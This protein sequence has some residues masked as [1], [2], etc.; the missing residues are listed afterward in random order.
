CRVET[1]DG[2]HILADR[3]RVKQV[4]LNLLSNA[5]KYNREGGKVTVSWAGSPDGMLHIKVADTG[6]G[7]P[8]DQMERLFSEFDRLG[9]EQ[10]DVEGT[11]LG[12]CLSR[13]LVQAMGGTIRVESEVGTGS[14]FTVELPLAEPPIQRQA[15]ELEEHLSHHQPVTRPRT[16]LHIEDNPSNL[17]LIQ[18]IFR[19]R[20]EITLLSAMLGRIG[21]EL[22]REHQPDLIL[23][24]IHL[25]DLPGTEVLRCLREDPA[26]RLIPVI[27]LSGD[28]TESQINKLLAAGARDY[29]TKPFDLSTFLDTVG[30][31]LWDRAGSPPS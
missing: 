4:L 9:A 22:A 26:T 14:T 18:R 21:L 12:L 6:P 8:R 10:T 11:G 25:P 2:L 23:L 31:V 13:G 24:D 1:S 30:E 15:H 20:P 27:A 3:Q 17:K 19:D 7:I 5:I 28:A 16:V 29:L